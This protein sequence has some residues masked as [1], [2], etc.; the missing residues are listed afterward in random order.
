MAPGLMMIWSL[1]ILVVAI[2]YVQ[3]HEPLKFTDHRLYS[4]DVN[5]SQSIID[6]LRQMSD[7]VYLDFWTDLTPGLKQASIRVPPS[8]IQHFEEFLNSSKV[9]YA[10]LTDNLQYWIDRERAENNHTLANDFLEG[11]MGID[12]FRLD[13]YHNYYEVRKEDGVSLA[14]GLCNS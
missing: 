10:V 1:A 7:I 14:I 2:G 3:S 13:L 8:S 5:G 9:P 6:G 4:V 11:R 12:G